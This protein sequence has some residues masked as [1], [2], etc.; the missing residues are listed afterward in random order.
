MPVRNQNWYDLQSGRRYPIDD[1]STCLDDAGNLLPNDI[2]VD[3]HIQAPSALGDSLFIQAV[4]IT[5]N[6]VTVLIGVS[7]SGTVA[8]IA[9]ISLQKPVESFVN[10]SVTPL[11]DGVAGWIVFGAGI[12]NAFSGRYATSAQTKIAPR[13]A[14][15]YSALPV[16]AIG[17]Q[18]L[19][20]ALTGIINIICDTPIVF[21]K[22]VIEINGKQATAVVFKLDGTVGNFDY[23]PLSYFLG[24]CGSRPESGTCPSQ[25]IETINGVAPDCA[26]NI[27]I[28]GDGVTIQPFTDCGGFG[29]D[30][31][32]GLADACK[33]TPY[34]P[35][36]E[37]IDNCE[38][39]VP[40]S[41]T[42]SSSSSGGTNPGT[43]S[44]STAQSS[45]TA[46]T[47]T[48]P[49]CEPFTGPI[50]DIVDVRTGNFAIKT[51]ELAVNDPGKCA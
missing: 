43:S 49:V 38:N 21:E 6:I 16:T 36:R 4:T 33:K 9:A 50:A 11:T 29:V 24:P 22:K 27:N 31:G 23:N 13:N 28:V 7:T 45:T 39:A 37:P 48:L 3:C 40:G 32:L 42:S 14:P 5:D 47:R 30:V 26:G 2:I 19:S 18:G 41:S 20:Q 10:Y 51:V 1:T 15:L 46:V 34:G 35:P 8:S 12:V 44:S 17:K 25:P